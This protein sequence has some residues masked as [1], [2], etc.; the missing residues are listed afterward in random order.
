MKS[1]YAVA[2][3]FYLKEGFDF[4]EASRHAKADEDMWYELLMGK[5]SND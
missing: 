4:K 1:F 3:D 5:K 2:R